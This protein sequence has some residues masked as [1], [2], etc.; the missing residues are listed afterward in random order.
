MPTARFFSFL[1]F[2]LLGVG[3]VAA[4]G[5]DSVAPD[6]KNE[7]P[8][9]ERVLDLVK[10]AYYDKEFLRVNSEQTVSFAKLRGDVGQLE[11]DTPR[12]NQLIKDGGS[13]PMITVGLDI[14][15]DMR[16]E[17]FSVEVRNKESIHSEADVK[18]SLTQVDG[19]PMVSESYWYK[20]LGSGVSGYRD[21]E[22]YESERKLG[23]R[24]FQGEH[25]L[26]SKIPSPSCGFSE[27]AYTWFGDSKQAE[28][29]AECIG[30]SRSVESAPLD[31]RRVWFLTRLADDSLD[32]DKNSVVHRSV[33]WDFYWIS[34]D[35]LILGW[36]TELA[37]I[38]PGKRT[39]CLVTDR[40][41]SYSR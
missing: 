35:G 12:P 17:S 23:I 4:W 3:L 41:Y 8:T 10:R 19:K 15:S 18:F 7:V 26:F 37:D 9:V 29:W 36:R 24:R 5:G 21:I 39:L 6:A 25:S 30:E 27:F 33:R 22:P 13:P 20:D 16:R 28:T 31:G 1:A 40:S 2:V 34:E 14:V 38:V 11:G 32:T